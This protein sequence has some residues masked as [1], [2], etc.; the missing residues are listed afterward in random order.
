MSC[1]T[2]YKL[3]FGWEYWYDRCERTWFAAQFD[4]EGNQ[5]SHEAHDAYHKS[6]ILVLVNRDIATEERLLQSV[7]HRSLVEFALGKGYSIEVV[8]LTPE[9]DIRDH[10]IKDAKTNPCDIIN[11]IEHA[12]VY[13]ANHKDVCCM[14]FQ[15]PDNPLVPVW[16]IVD[17]NAPAGES[18]VT[19]HSGGIVRDWEAL[20]TYYGT[21]VDSKSFL[22]ATPLTELTAKQWEK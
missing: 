14:I 13:D 6:S 12:F 1:G 21:R 19:S 22:Y 3:K 20:W 16:A 15:Y 9:L 4:T 2:I 17:L 5:I 7:S 10:D 8:G 11:D 18:T